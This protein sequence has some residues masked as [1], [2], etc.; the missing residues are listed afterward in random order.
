MPQSARKEGGR[1]Q[2]GFVCVAV[3][4]LRIV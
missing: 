2:A 1:K 4:A 3:F